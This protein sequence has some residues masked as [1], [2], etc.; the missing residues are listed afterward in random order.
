M[1]RSA[2]PNTA[3]LLDWLEGRLPAA[4]ASS[5]AQAVADDPALHAQVAWLR[6]FLRASRATVLVDPPPELLQSVNAHFAAYARQQRGPGP[7]RT[8]IAALTADSWQRLALSGMRAASLRS[9][10]RQVIYSSELA[11]VALNIQAQPGSLHY[12]LEGQVFAP[13]ASPSARFV[14]QLL[15]EGVERRLA[16]SDSLGKFSLAELPTGVYELLVSSDQ[17]EIEIGPIELA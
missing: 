9:V 6:D 8:F 7:V 2:P 10:P 17:G 3:L 5:L 11:D 15:Q 16:L 1:T 12:A 14:A 4:Q 13:E